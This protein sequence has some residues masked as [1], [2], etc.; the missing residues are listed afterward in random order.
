MAAAL[1]F[2]A[3]LLIKIP[4]PGSGGAYLNFGDAVIYACAFIL[5]GPLGA[6][7]AGIGS[8][9]AD[10]VAG[11]AV[12]ALSTVIIK[13]A[14]GLIVG[15]MTVS[16]RF[17]SYCFACTMA[18][19]VMVGGYALLEWYFFGG[20]YA[21][22]TLPFNLFQWFGSVLVALVLY[23]GIRRLSSTLGLRTPGALVPEPARR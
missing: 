2:L 1:V 20:A 22:A 3:T 18:G 12:Y 16:Q 10:I 13:C 8:G 11:S 4:V 19:A 6:A 9:L 7:A 23:R 5:G 17:V 14:M 15:A 21:A